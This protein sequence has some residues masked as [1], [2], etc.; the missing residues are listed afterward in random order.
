MSR[1]TQ[2]PFRKD[3][4]CVKCQAGPV[5]MLSYAHVLS[6]GT[7]RIQRSSVT[8]QP[9]KTSVESPNTIDVL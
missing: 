5:Q 8:K 3:T 7:L 9:R 2:H 4:G 6:K 1:V